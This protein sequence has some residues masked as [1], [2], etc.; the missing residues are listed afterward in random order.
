MKQEAVPIL[1]LYE[2][3]KRFFEISFEWKPQLHNLHEQF[4][5]NKLQ[6]V[7]GRLNFPFPPHRQSVYDFV[8]LT[9]GRSV[10][11]KGLDKYEFCA[12]T[13]FFARLSN[14]NT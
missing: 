14:F 13:F 10:R 3:E 8:F 6:D 4:H 9:Q 2:K 7:V 5:I 11:S 12:D 1:S